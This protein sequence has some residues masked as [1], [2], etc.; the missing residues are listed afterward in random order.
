MNP[1]EA[2]QFVAGPYA[3]DAIALRRWDEAAKDPDVEVP[4]FARFAPLLERVVTPP[5]SR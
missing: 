2:K 3:E 1:L 5:A 4:T